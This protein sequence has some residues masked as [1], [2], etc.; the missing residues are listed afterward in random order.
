MADTIFLAATRAHATFLLKDDRLLGGGPRESPRSL[1]CARDLQHRS[2]Q[3]IHECRVAER[4]AVAAD[5]HQHGRRAAGGTSLRR[6]A[7]AVGQ[8]R[9][10]YLH[11]YER[12]PR[13]W[14]G[15]TRY[16]Q[17]FNQRRPH[18][19]LRSRIPDDGFFT[20]LPDL[21]NHSARAIPLIPAA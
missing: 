8:I 11:A 2:R 3:P 21:L 19:G 20:A 4:A 7:L 13:V 6:A 12:V 9:Q 5:R 17:F 18:R 1:R 14:A 10:V 15:L 16:F